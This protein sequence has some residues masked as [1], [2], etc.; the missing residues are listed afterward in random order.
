MKIGRIGKSFLP[1]IDKQE[2]R[3]SISMRLTYWLFVAKDVGI[4]VSGT[5]SVMSVK[6]DSDVFC[7]VLVHTY[8]N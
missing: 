1:C 7:L 8:F 5:K 3:L 2:V 6:L 4:F